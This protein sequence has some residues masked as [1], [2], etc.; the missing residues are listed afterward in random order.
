MICRLLIGTLLFLGLSASNANAETRYALLI[1]ANHGDPGETTLRYAVEDVARVR[2]VLLSLG[3][4]KAENIISLAEPSAN[5]IRAVWAKLNARIRVE[6]ASGSSSLVLV[7]YSGHADAKALHLDGTR[8]PWEELRN[9]V[10]GSAASARLLIVDAC[11]SGQ[12]TRVKGTRLASSFA[13]PKMDTLPEGMAILSSAAA[14]ESAQ[15]SDIIRGSFFTH[16]FVAGLRGMADAN[17]DSRVT[18][19]E[20]YQ[21]T[22]DRTIASSAQ[23]LAGLQHPT[24]R[25][26]LKGRSDLVIA[27]LTGSQRLSTLELSRRGQY[28]IRRDGPQGPLVIEAN[29]GKR[30]RQLRLPAGRYFIQHRMQKRFREGSVA[31][32]PGATI[33]T[34]DLSMHSIEYARLVRK[35]GG[36]DRSYSA[37]LWAGL[38]GPLLKELGLGLASAATVSIDTPDLSLDLEFEASRSQTQSEFISGSLSGIGFSAGLR[39]AFDLRLATVSLGLRLGAAFF[40]Q[41]Y[42]G[43]RL[44][45]SRQRLV[46]HL[47]TVLRSEVLAWDSVTVGIEMRLRTSILRKQQG[48][49]ATVRE[50]PVQPMLLLGIGRVW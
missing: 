3:G 39:K 46:P 14:G 15:E 38:S 1:G 32:S 25:Y 26:Q 44:A 19:A 48:I 21:Y 29:V 40:D 23:T 41:R 2:E 24:Y 27:T 17:R 7:Y 35:G 43:Q 45:P 36:R 28:L 22:A 31:L 47:D 8:L 9:S 13:I 18:L 50:T 20:A 30:Q 37:T 6:S 34:R 11:R 42:S 16:H 5:R 4:F 10:S 49:D 12:I 33:R